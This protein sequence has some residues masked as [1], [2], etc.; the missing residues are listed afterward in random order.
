MHAGQKNG[1]EAD[2]LLLIMT[3][4]GQQP[5]LRVRSWR[6]RRALGVGALRDGVYLAPNRPKLQAMLEAQA[7]E[8]AAAGGSARVLKVMLED[9]D[10]ID[11]FDRSTEYRDLTESAMAVLHGR[12]K[13]SLKRAAV[14]LQRL[15][16]DF[17]AVV[18]RDYFPG[19][20][21]Q[22]ARRAFDELRLRL[23]RLRTPDEPH[24]VRAQI[25]QL[26]KAQHQGRTWITRARPWV[27]RLA[28]AWVIRRFIDPAARF[29]WVKHP[30]KRLGSMLGF[31]FDGATFTHVDEKVTFEVLQAT[32]G[33][34]GDAALKRLA[35][36][37]HY[38]DVGGFPV[39]ESAAVEAALRGMRA[40][41]RNDHKLLAR[42]CLL[43]DDL[44][45]GYTAA[46]AP[47]VRAK[48]ARSEPK[49]IR[50]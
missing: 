46:G 13:R 23:E 16:R 21:Q 19:V 9:G 41:I 4:P 10:F 42:A 34:E 18:Q 28:S 31:D 24:A 39:P 44:Y 45:A 49:R 1:S 6:K 15:E 3:I 7:R 17:E 33:L 26:D 8:V 20:A 29:R 30:P 40:R 2:W 35:A 38:L 11:L 36:I 27:D 32:F 12:G 47:A 50:A 5:A 37:V 43:F 14:T 22:H 48:G 25:P